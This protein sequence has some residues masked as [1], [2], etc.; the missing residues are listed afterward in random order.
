MNMLGSSDKSRGRSR[1]RRSLVAV[2]A[3]IL[4]LSGLSLPV[5]AL[6]ITQSPSLFGCLSGQ[7]LVDVPND[8]FI[9]TGL[10]WWVAEVLYWDAN[11]QTWYRAGFGDYHWSYGLGAYGFGQLDVRSMTNYSTG[12][13]EEYHYINVTP[14]YYYTVVNWVYADGAWGA[15]QNAYIPDTG[16]DWWCLA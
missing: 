8:T 9:S 5:Q 14:G 2:V 13:V 7:L 6:T 16:G 3:L 11:A 15:G 10:T 1:R 12:V 4:L